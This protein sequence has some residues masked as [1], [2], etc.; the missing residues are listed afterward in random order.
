MLMPKDSV[1]GAPTP[2]QNL[3]TLGSE[4]VRV[5]PGKGGRPRRGKVQF[6][7]K[8]K[9]GFAECID[10]HL[11]QLSAVTGRKLERADILEMMLET[12]EAAQQ[13]ENGAAALAAL[14][15]KDQP[16]EDRAAGRTHEMRLWATDDVFTALTIE[17]RERGWTLSRVIEALL[18]EVTKTRAH[19][20]AF[21]RAR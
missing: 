6:N 5:A 14:A 19:P 7:N 4:Q 3:S 16:P 18:I 12:F 17:A 2:V 10:H 13:G 9:P 21:Q 20:Q 15:R 1:L 8:V 11:L